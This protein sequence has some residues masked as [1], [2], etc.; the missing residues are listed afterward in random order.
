MTTPSGAISFSDVQ[1]EFGGSNP[2][3]LSEYY[4]GGSNVPSVGAGTSGIPTSNT[5][6]ADNLRGRSK[7]AT[8]TYDVL[9]AG[10]GGGAG[11]H[12]ELPGSKGTYAY[13]GGSASLSGSGITTVTS[14]GGGGGE[15]G[16]FIWNSPTAGQSSAHGTGGAAGAEDNPGGDGSGSGAGG[17]GGGGNNSGGA[18][19]QGGYAGTRNTG[20]FTLVYGT[21]LTMTIGSGGNGTS[22]SPR[23]GGNGSGGRV[24]LS[25]DSNSPAYTSSTTRVV[26]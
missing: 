16:A 5:I 14:S 10:G 6:S 25:W 3:S 12:S 7:T 15:N 22:H 8:V 26:N 4:R 18:S 20:S 9:G 23:S 11:Y 19:G 17:G 21:T 2:I 13:S 1:T 24:S